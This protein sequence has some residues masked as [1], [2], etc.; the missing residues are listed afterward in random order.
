MTYE[1]FL[2]Q[3]PEMAQEKLGEEY[4]V[5]VT[6][7]AK[8]N[9][10]SRDGLIIRKKGEEIVPVLYLDEAYG[11]IEDGMPMSKFVENILQLIAGRKE[12]PSISGERFLDP[13][14]VRKRVIWRLVHAEKNKELLKRVPFIPF[15]DLAIVFGIY[16]ENN[17]SGL[18]VARIENW[19]L[20]QWGM[21]V[22]D[23]YV[24][25]RENSPLL[26]PAAC[27][28]AAHL[29]GE[30]GFSVPE[31]EREQHIFILTNT[32]Q[33]FGAGVILYDGVLEGLSER[34]GTDLLLLPVNVH[35]FA[36][37][38]KGKEY[39]DAIREAVQEHGRKEVEKED[40]LSGHAYCYIRETKQIE[41]LKE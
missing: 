23:L 19:H 31:D 9:G 40:F 35:G 36:V 30:Y 24:M 8:N 20:R 7:I 1:E 17:E 25:A 14:W 13:S 32:C 29:F 10:Y 33:C 2:H 39:C 12:Q 18:A 34:Y 27:L 5:T 15:L 37:I 3:V 38:P 6:R 16:V 21:T 11:Q 41:M 4:K 26:M 22:P 28:D